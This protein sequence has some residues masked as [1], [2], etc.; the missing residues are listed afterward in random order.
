MTPLRN[1][2]VYIRSFGGTWCDERGRTNRMPAFTD[3]LQTNQ[4]VGKLTYTLA[5]GTA[6]VSDVQ[7][8][9]NPSVV[10]RR[11]RSRVPAK[12]ATV[13]LVGR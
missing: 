8:T 2:K 13:C 10:S 5:P 4:T 3:P 12:L 1:G 11:R 7:R 9:G 6:R